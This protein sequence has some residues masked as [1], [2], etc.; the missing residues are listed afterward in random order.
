MYLQKVISRKFLFKISVLLASWRSKT[1]M[2]DPDPH[3]HPFFFV[4]GMDPRIRIRILTKMSWITNTAGNWS[5]KASVDIHVPW[6]NLIIQPTMTIYHYE[7]PRSYCKVSGAWCWW[8]LSILLIF[9][10]KP[11]KWVLLL[12]DLIYGTCTF[13]YIFIAVWFRHK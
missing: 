9:F 12:V 13:F 7:I 1:K 3:P 8:C 10:T 4:R 2:Q 11:F 6:E 5:W